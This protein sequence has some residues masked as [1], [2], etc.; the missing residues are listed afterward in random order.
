MQTK[1]EVP[2]MRWIMKS[3]MNRMVRDYQSATNRAN[4]L[5][6]HLADIALAIGKRSRSEI[7]IQ[8]SASCGTCKSALINAD[9]SGILEP[10]AA[11]P[12]CPE[13]DNEASTSLIAQYD[14]LPDISAEPNG[15][16]GLC[17]R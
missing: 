8:A 16:P 1:R 13:E 15:K 5:R 7:R 12:I 10:L 11:S 3:K 4:Q 2:A 17:A 14:V 9:S 6:G